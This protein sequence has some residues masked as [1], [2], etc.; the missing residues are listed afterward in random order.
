MHVGGTLE[1][2]PL[3]VCARAP[4]GDKSAELLIKSGA[5]PAIQ[6]TD[7]TTP[8]H[9]AV[10]EGALKIVRLLLLEGAN[11]STTN[12]NGET[13][14][15]IAVLNCHYDVVRE[16]LDHI[17]RTEGPAGATAAVNAQDD[18]RTFATT[19]FSFTC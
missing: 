18:V 12:H 3:H 7:G 1:E 8:L 15:H 5:N 11:N 19:I 17:S 16:L 13:P 10:T 14:L 9:C 2:A 6:M 4:F